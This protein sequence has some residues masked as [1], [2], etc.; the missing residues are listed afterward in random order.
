MPPWIARGRIVADGGG[1]R[2]MGIV[3]ATPDSFSDGGPPSTRPTPSPAERWPPRGPTSSTSAASRPAPAP[4]RP[5]RGRIRRVVPVVE[6]LA[7]RLA[8]RSPSTRPSPRSP[9]APSGRRRDPQR[10]HGA[11]RPRHARPR[12]RVGRGVVLMHMQGTP[13]TMQIDPHYDDVVARSSTSSPPGS[14]AAAAGI[15]RERIAIDPGIGFGKTTAQPRPLAWPRSI[16]HA[17]LRAAGRDLAQGL[18]RQDHRPADRH[19][20]ATASVACA[21]GDPGRARGLSG[22]TTSARWSTRSRSG[23]PLRLR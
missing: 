16:R 9:A 10:H 17:G 14:T 2:V 21:R 11:G 6:A 12:R 4:R 5:D 22:S 18:P 7:A 13:R 3:N 1:P 23:K 20:R 19:D 15:P 8:C